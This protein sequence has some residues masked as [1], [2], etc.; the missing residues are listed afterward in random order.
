MNAA[1]LMTE[2]AWRFR[3]P[4]DLASVSHDDAARAIEI[5]ARVLTDV[6]DAVPANCR[7]Q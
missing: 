7:M 3:Y 2:F 6:S 1:A 5:A 4:G